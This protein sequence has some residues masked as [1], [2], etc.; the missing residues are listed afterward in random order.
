MGAPTDPIADMLT[1]MRNALRARHQKADV[2]AS[3]IK[4]EIARVMKEE[5]FLAAYKMIEE[6]KKKT[7]RLYLKYGPNKQSVISGLRRV[8]KPGRRVYR[9][10]VGIKPV[11]GGLGLNILTTPQGIMSG[12]QARRQG[13]GGEVLCE[14]W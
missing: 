14:V 2:P 4:G 12:R 1:S 11:F 3:K 7:L 9:A 5:G 13:V 6:N 10:R 8:S